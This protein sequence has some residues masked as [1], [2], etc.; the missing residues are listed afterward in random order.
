MNKTIR[1]NVTL[2]TGLEIR[3]RRMVNG[4]TRAVGDRAMTE[5][6]YEEYWNLVKADKV[7]ERPETVY[8][9]E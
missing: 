7:P 3:H 2:S 4:A 6:E 1:C 8:D 9:Q 5:A